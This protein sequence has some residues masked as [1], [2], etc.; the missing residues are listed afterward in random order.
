[1]LGYIEIEQGILEI[2]RVA[3]GRDLLKALQAQS[4]G[5]GFISTLISSVCLL[6]GNA[7]DVTKV[8]DFDAGVSLTIQEV[9]FEPKSLV[10]I[11]LD[12][13]P[14]SYA[15]DE[16]IVTLNEPRKIKHD[17][18]ATRFAN[19]D[20]TAIAFWLIS[21]L[22]SIDEKKLTYDDVLDLPAG[23]VQALMQLVTPKKPTFVRQKI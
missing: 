22:V 19:G 13:Y 20:N 6:N 23:E 4:K 5:E 16:R 2:K 12:S 11:D 21:F 14:K 10:P 3:T 8:E 18:Q 17:N 15:L 9:I 1:M 7:V